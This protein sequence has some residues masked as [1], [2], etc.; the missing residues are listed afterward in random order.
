LTLNKFSA[1]GEQWFFK[2]SDI[3]KTLSVSGY[4]A[5]PRKV[6]GNRKK[7][8]MELSLKPE[9]ATVNGDELH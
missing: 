9:V 8:A 1:G 3:A 7:V 2:F 5:F 6:I 4:V